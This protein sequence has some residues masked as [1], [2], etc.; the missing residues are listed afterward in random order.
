MEHMLTLCR[1]MECY[2]SA[3][4]FIL[5]KFLVM[6]VEL[7]IHCM[8]LPQV[9]LPNL[10]RIPCHQYFNHLWDLWLCW[11]QPPCESLALTVVTNHARMV[12]FPFFETNN[13]ISI[14]R[15][16]LPMSIIMCPSNLFLLYLISRVLL[17]QLVFCCCIYQVNQTLEQSK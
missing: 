17:Y 14:K 9:V 1:E 3:V 15:A 2:L 4:M 6:I 5:E 10:L 16:D 7:N 8:I 13:W 11:H 12:S